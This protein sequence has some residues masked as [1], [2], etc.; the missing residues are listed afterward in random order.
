VNE[1][2]S[3]ERTKLRDF[4]REGWTPKIDIQGFASILFE[5][6][7][8]RPITS[9]TSIPT[10]IPAFV[11]SII[12]SGLRM[13]SGTERS[14]HDIFDILKANDFEIEDGI[15]SSEVSAFVNWVEPAEYPAK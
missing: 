8:G 14:L 1:S 7:V 15:D 12:E 13:N 5:I 3:E 2:E 9:E 4:S 10:T 11:Y 6:V